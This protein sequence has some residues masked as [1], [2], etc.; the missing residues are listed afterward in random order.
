MGC[1]AAEA[2]GWEAQ[3]W[4]WEPGRLAGV[5]RA[6]G[7]AERVMGCLAQRVEASG[8]GLGSAGAV[9]VQREQAG[10]KGVVRRQAASAQPLASAT[11]SATSSSWLTQGAAGTLHDRRTDGEGDGSACGQVTTSS[12]S[13]L[14]AVG[15]STETSS[16][17]KRPGLVRAEHMLKQADAQAIGPLRQPRTC[18]HSCCS[19][20]HSRCQPLLGSAIQRIYRGLAG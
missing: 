3:G 8:T 12:N 17:R 11:G 2:K 6:P 5:E 13:P 4:D 19:Q 16:A 18:C 9:A 10:S 14:R 15:S 20:L 7:W 1:L